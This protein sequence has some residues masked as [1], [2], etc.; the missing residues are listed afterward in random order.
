[1]WG[2]KLVL[3]YSFEFVDGTT[4]KKS[5]IVFL[6]MTRLI[7]LSLWCWVGRPFS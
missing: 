4:I 1:M 3:N 5:R 2:E 6:E 7:E